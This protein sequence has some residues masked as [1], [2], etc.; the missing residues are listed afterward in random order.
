M[1]FAYNPPGG[2][3]TYKVVIFLSIYK[4]KVYDHLGISEEN[5]KVFGRILI[6]WTWKITTTSWILKEYIMHKWCFRTDLTVW[7]GVF[8]R[9][10]KCCSHFLVVKQPIR[11]RRKTEKINWKKTNVY[12]I[13]IFPL[14]SLL[15]D[16]F[17]CE[18]EI[19]YTTT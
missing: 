7:S 19:I 2:Q 12:I 5:K 15:F 18:E 14:L 10:D 6:S 13:I 3:I 9:Y 11:K 4:K 1:C 8:K 17:F 16:L